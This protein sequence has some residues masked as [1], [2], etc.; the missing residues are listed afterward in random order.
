MIPLRMKCFMQKKAEAPFSMIG[1][2]VYLAVIICQEALL[3]TGIPFALH[4][5]K[6]RTK[7]Q[8]AMENIMPLVA[9]VRRFGAASLDLAYVAAG[10]FDGY[11]E[12]PLQP[13]DMAAG[14]VLVR[15]AEA[16]FVTFKVVMIFLERNRF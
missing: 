13:W 12:H 4:D 8:R 11:W 5:T 2:C 9:G 3:G 10:R 1:V 14:I 6:T 16:I 15:E 7:F